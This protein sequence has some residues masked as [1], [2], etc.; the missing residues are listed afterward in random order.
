MTP[1]AAAAH[2]P[3]LQVTAI[4]RTVREALER[5]CRL[6]I[7]VALLSAALIVLILVEGFETVVQPRRVTRRYRISR[8]YYVAGWA[9]WQW[10][11]RSLFGKSKRRAAFLS[12]FG[13]LSLLGIFATWVL[14]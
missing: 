12:I 3:R 1:A 8:L 9:S 2:A 6:R 10:A 5:R 11:A 7:L 14:G 4:V 13:P